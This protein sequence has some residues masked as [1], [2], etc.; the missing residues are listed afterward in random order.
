MS[1]RRAALKPL[2]PSSKFRLVSIYSFSFEPLAVL[3]SL[4]TGKSE[5]VSIL[6]ALPKLFPPA[7][8]QLG[9]DETL[10]KR[11]CILPRMLPFVL[12]VEDR[13]ELYSGE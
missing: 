11:A 1:E 8:L 2:I 9:D 12:W 3:L 4:K 5:F 10:L 6:T 13:G 7:L